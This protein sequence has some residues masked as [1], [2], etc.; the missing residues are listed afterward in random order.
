MSG[1]DERRRERLEERMSAL[2]NST[3]G[4]APPELEN[5]SEGVDLGWWSAGDGS[6]LAHVRRS[7]VVGCFLYSYIS[8]YL[9]R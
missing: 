6:R 5:M 9:L 3:S 8:M 7:R 4:S 1:S 2:F